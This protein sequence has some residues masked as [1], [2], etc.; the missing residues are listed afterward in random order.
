MERRGNEQGLLLCACRRT[1]VKSILRT[2]TQGECRSDK[3]RAIHGKKKG[4]HAIQHKQTPRR[5][6]NSPVVCVS[7]MDKHPG[8]DFPRLA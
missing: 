5:L 7:L 4:G 2:T 3:Y 8:V 1:G 6:D